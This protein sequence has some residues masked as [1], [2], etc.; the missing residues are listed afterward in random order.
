[1]F[2]KLLM[3]LS[4]ALIV[5]CSLYG[6][7]D[8]EFRAKYYDETT[9]TWT[10]PPPESYSGRLANLEK[11]VSDIVFN[12]SDS[13]PL[14][15]D[16]LKNIKLRLVNDFGNVWRLNTQTLQD[17]NRT[18]EPLRVI[19]SEL[20]VSE[21]EYE[22]AYAAALLSYISPTQSSKKTLERLAKDENKAA[23]DTS[24]DA[25]FEMNWESPELRKEIVQ[26]LNEKVNGTDSALAS[27]S[28]NWV[29]N[30]KLKEAIPALT[31][32]LESHYEKHKTIN[33]SVTQLA[34]FG[35]DAD[36]A[37]PLLYRIYAEMMSK[38]EMHIR[39][40]EAL[41]RAIIAL[42]G[43]LSGKEQAEELVH[44]PRMETTPEP[45]TVVSA[46]K[47]PVKVPSIEVAEEVPAESSQWW[48]W[49]VGLLVV[50]GGLVVV[51]RRKS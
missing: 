34:K 30:W 8:E 18:M 40:K 51:V 47:E 31:K 5:S 3:T 43:S 7:T 12:A 28:R 16:Q 23:A 26:A 15:L 50:L 48:L 14:E 13:N 29:G 38:G 11:N 27:H 20:A 25:L 41:E 4:L 35:K 49:L 21:N 44:A 6:Y 9:D 17:I 39:Q 37:L 36:A 24:L 46:K 22:R 1:M 19:A 32:L 2:Q 33:S 45:P 42:G 10:F